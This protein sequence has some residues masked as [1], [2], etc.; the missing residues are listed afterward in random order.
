MCVFIVLYN[1]QD[2]GLLKLRS[3]CLDTYEL[4]ELPQLDWMND[5]QMVA[6]IK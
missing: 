3:P 4:L 2:Q 1:F 5:A 6:A